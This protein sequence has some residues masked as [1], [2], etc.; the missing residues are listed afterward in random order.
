MTK[1]KAICMIAIEWVL[2]LI[3]AALFEVFLTNDMP[4][5]SCNVSYLYPPEVLTYASIFG[6]GLVSIVTVIMY[7]KISY[8]AI[9]NTRRTIGDY[10]LSTRR[11]M[12]S[13]EMKVTKML[14]LVLGIYFVFYIPSLVSAQLV[15]EDNMYDYKW[16]IIRHSVAVLWYATHA[17][18]PIIYASTNK[19]FQKAFKRLL[20]TEKDQTINSESMMHVIR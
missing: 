13:I 5:P 12:A 7:A 9:R 19:H 2:I 8:L 4:P 15:P 3:L 14:L 16:A 6:F 18:N 11:D 20:H 17:V 10:A 1:V